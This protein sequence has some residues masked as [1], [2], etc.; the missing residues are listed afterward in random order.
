MCK[1]Q[2]WEPL[3]IW[4]IITICPGAYTLCFPHCNVKN[5]RSIEWPHNEFGHFY[6]YPIYID[7][8]NPR[9]KLQCILIY[10]QPFSRYKVVQNRQ[11]TIWPQIDL[12]HL[13]VNS[14]HCI[15]PF[16]SMTSLF[17]GT[18][19]RRKWEMSLVI[20]DLPWIFNWQTYPIYIE[21]LPAE[22]KFPSVL[23]YDQ[24]FWDTRLLIIL[25]APNDL[26]LILNTLTVTIVHCALNTCP[27]GLHFSI[28]APQANSR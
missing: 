2:D 12:K 21:Y 17:P 14:T 15:F 1:G 22:A 20:S 10:C 23:L 5:W 26:M 3:N 4:F 11:C 8:L 16:C 27:R 6:K 9:P 28:F 7:D 25:N 18:R 19:L 24:A 13:T